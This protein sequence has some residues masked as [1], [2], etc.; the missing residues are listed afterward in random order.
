ML[1][2]S[3]FLIER[4]T[5]VDNENEVHHNRMSIL[6]VIGEIYRRS[7]RVVD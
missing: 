1:I 7:T 3:P 6:A 5:T 4:D 2:R